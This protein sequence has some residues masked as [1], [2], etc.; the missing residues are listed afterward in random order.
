MP[1]DY[2]AGTSMGALVGAA[3]A[4]GM[5][6]D[7]IRDLL[8]ESEWSLIFSGDTPYTLKDFRRKEDSREFP[9]RFELGLRRGIRLPSSIDPGHQVGLLLSRIALPYSTVESFDLLP[10]P[11]RCVATNLE[12]AELVIMKDGSLPQALS[13]TM[14]IPGLFPPVERNGALLADGGLL[15]NVPADV[16]RAMGAEVVVAIDVGAPLRD[17]VELGSAMGHVNQAIDIMIRHAATHGLDEADLVVRPQVGDLSMDDWRRSDEIADRGYDAM[18]A[19]ASSLERLS[20]G[21][22]AWTAHLERRARRTRSSEIVPEF[23]EIQGVDPRARGAI[24]QRLE[25]YIGKPL[26]LERLEL[27]L[28]VLTGTGR[29]RNV[30]YEARSRDGRRGLLILLRQKSHGPPF[31]NF[32]LDIN[33]EFQDI[34]FDFGSRFTAFDVGKYGAELRSDVS[35]GTRLGLA[36]EYYRPFGSSR[37]FFAP[38]ALAERESDR[39]FDDEELVAIYRRTRVSVG[40]DLGLAWGPRSEIRAGYGLSRIAL[41]LRVGSPVLP[42][43]AGKEEVLRGRWIFDGHDSATIP[44]RGVRSTVALRFFLDTPLAGERFALAETHVSAFRPLED[45]H[46]IFVQ[47]SAGTSFDDTPTVLHQF[48]LGGPLRLSAFG[49]DEFRGDHFLLGAAGYLRAVGRLPDFLGRSIYLAGITEAGSAFETFDE[50][51]LHASVTAGLVMDTALGPIFLG[52]SL[53]DG[54]SSRVHFALGKLFR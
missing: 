3:Y 52:G 20:V 54:G 1:I 50:A 18:E 4:T 23:I 24:A 38:R 36:L 46:R 53:G 40:G 27:D 51:D 12:Q 33:N 37:W 39:F 43:V 30:R 19:V 32:A 25:P 17:G 22:A 10:T 49:V 28:T 13:A 26:D 7:E 31:I 5:S 9:V 45:G 2:I 44:S 42:E 47:A 14:A 6:P 41:G 15:N 29:Y 11:F 34:I 21:E 35:L 16:V 48:T 8:N